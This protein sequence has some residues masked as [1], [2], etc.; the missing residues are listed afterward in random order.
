MKR[1]RIKLL[2]KIDDRLFG[3]GIG[4]IFNAFTGRKIFK[5]KSG[6]ERSPAAAARREGSQ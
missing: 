1:L 3:D 4:A 2:G 6:H 5:V